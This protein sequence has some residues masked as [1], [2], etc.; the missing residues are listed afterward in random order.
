MLWWYIDPSLGPGHHCLCINGTKA[1]LMR[2]PQSSA[3]GA[4]LSTTERVSI[5]GVGNEILD[6]SPGQVRT[7]NKAQLTL[8]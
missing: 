6:I 7:V 1:K 5:G 8:S 2:D 3:I 4:P